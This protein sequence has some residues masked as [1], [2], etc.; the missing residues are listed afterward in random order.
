MP[1]TWR[2]GYASKPKTNQMY[3]MTI[4]LTAQAAGESDRPIDAL[5]CDPSE[6]QRDRPIAQ[7]GQ[8][9]TTYPLMI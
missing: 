9:R 5:S 7:I 1:S 6:A 8:M 4:Y 2:L 3:C